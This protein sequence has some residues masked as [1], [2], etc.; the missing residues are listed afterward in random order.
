[1]YVNW[2]SFR[3]YNKLIMIITGISG[4]ENGWME[5][6]QYWLCKA[7]IGTQF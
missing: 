7:S 6:T 2:M 3:K 5:T 4:L 1:M